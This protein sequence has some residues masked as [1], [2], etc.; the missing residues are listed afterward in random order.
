[1]E[2][3]TVDSRM[4]VITGA[5]NGIGL[6]MT[7][8]LLEMGDRVAGLDLSTDNLDALQRDEGRLRSYVC[9]VTDRER[10]EHVV[11][12]VLEAWGGVDVLVNNACLAIFKPYLERTPE[13]T[14]REFE[15]NYFGCLTMIDAVLPVMR[16]QGHG[17]IHNVS[18]G[19][20]LTGYPGI[21]GYASTKGAI[22]ALT[23]TLALEFEP[24]GITVNLIH[25]PLTRTQSSAP[26]GVPPEMMAD[27]AA[28]GR[29]LAR[30]IG[31]TRPV[32]TPDLGTS[33]GTA[34]N[35]HF[36]VRMGRFLARMAARAAKRAEED[37]STDDG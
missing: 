4:V 37:A 26:L 6:A 12:D 17:V 15:V 16:E 18:S 24:L 23:R 30:K 11:R 2:I 3:A 34:A 1:M 20:G 36:P 32:L 27:P 19:V 7:Q 9:D 28:V 14:R 25:P 8:A 21:S 31:Q 22:E 10:V 29:K 13:E 35:Q 33:L 5:N